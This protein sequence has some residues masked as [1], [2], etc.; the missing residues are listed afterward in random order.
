MR[1][2]KKLLAQLPTNKD[3]FF[4]I[5]AQQNNTQNNAATLN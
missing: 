1:K 5:S 2:A 4:F 3:A